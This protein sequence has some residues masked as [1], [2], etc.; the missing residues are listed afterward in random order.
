MAVARALSA[1]VLMIVAAAGVAQQAYPN[2]PI[3]LITPYPPGGTTSHLARIVGEKITA[4]W[5][6]QVLVE[7]RGGGNTIIGVEAA[8]RSAPDGY[9]LLLVVQTHVI[10]PNLMPT[11]YDPIKDFAPIGT[12]SKT[13]LTLVLHPSVPA[14]N[15]QEF[16]ALAKARPGELNYASSGGGTTTHLAA[17][18]FEY[19]NGVKMQHI[20]YKGGGPAM[21]DLLGGQVQ[22]YFQSPLVV[23]PF[24]KAGRIKG[25]AI[26]GDAR[27]PGM[28]QVPTFS[29]AGLPGF[30]LRIWYGILA[31]AGTPKEIVDKLSAE[32]TRILAMPDVKEKLENQGMAPFISTSTQ[33]G[34]LMAADLARF[35]Q[36]IKAAN[37]K[38]N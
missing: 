12:V 4:N 32:L 3:R 7:N 8:A 16:I 28:P 17:A 38:L 19:R 5:G 23:M 36:I 27:F 30:D 22:A 24:V 15:L 21:T 9:T 33:F 13:E 1:G 31:P 2:K 26:S 10:V 34:A 35:G 37:I 18:M 11:P 14:N 20:P 25:I 29:E 6:Q